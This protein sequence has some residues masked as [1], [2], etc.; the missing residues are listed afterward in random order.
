MSLCFKLEGQNEGSCFKVFFPLHYCN[1][2][3]KIHHCTENLQSLR[4]K[5]LIEDEGE[6]VCV[7]I[8]ITTRDL[9]K[10]KKASAA[11]RALAKEEHCYG[12]KRP[13]L[14]G[15]GSACV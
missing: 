11:Q 2:K 4:L 8:S 7:L 10:N 5:R 13:V 3:C 14:E 6:T 9:T 1:F 12:A 15:G